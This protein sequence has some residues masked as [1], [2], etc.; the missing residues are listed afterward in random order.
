MELH[1][2]D[3]TA[4]AELVR[5]GK[6]TPA[7]LVDAAIARIERHNPELNAVIWPMF[8]EARATA[9][10]PLPGGDNAEFRGVPFLVKDIVAQVKGTPYTAGLR[11]LKA[12]NLRAPRDS[13]LVESFRRAGFVICGKTN[14]S[15]LGIVPSVEPDAHGAAHNPY[16]TS[17][18]TG[19]SSGGSGAA[20][21]AGLVS[22]AH[23]NDG[24]GSIRIPAACCGLV[25]LKPSRGRVSVG[26][27]YGSING[28]LVC[29]HVVT[30][31][32]RD[33]ARVLD[34][35]QGARPGDPYA[36][37]TP[38][39]P[40]R[41]ELG[42]VTGKLRIGFAKRYMNPTGQLV[43]VHADAAAAVDHTA[44]LLESLGH[45]VEE[46][47][48]DALKSPEYVPRFLAVW[49]T[50]V[51]ADLE[52]VEILLKRKIAA[53]EVEPLTWGLAQMGKSVSAPGYVLAWRWLEANARAVAAFFER[54]DLWL[55][56]TVS[57]PPPKLGAFKS[58]PGNPLGGIFAA[59]EFAPFTPPFNA[60]GQPAISLPLFKNAAG[61]PIGSHL[62][63]AYGRE[64]LLIRVA[65]QLEAA[66]P[67]VHTATR[68]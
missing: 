50:G 11:P 31:S 57:G 64:D 53:E 44:K 43:G 25:G 28:G 15:E 66:Q 23:A 37:P 3:A 29:E 5:T 41:E 7:E 20:V 65:S 24:G 27:D 38:I 47:E 54:Y 45:H 22:I 16:D 36:A 9:R 26:P 60:T 13:Y 14:T 42:A 33:S 18:S 46:A 51:A 6:V 68:A 49:A 63:A 4:Q 10:G 34:L 40:Y 19:G 61:L 35:I 1:T 52:G 62:V 59:A 32:V 67:F 55:T 21:A 8:D 56:P 17:R 39:R 30:R 12:A 2:L 48:I 58:D